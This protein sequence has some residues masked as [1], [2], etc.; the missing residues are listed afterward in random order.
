M[1]PDGDNAH[2]ANKQRLS[3]P[4]D[5]KILKMNMKASF[6]IYWLCGLQ[7]NIASLSLW[8][9]IDWREKIILLWEHN[10]HSRE[11]KKRRN[12]WKETQCPVVLHH[13]SM[14]QKFRIY[15]KCRIWRVEDQDI[16][17]WWVCEVNTLATGQGWK[18]WV[19]DFS[20]TEGHPVAGVYTPP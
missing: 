16:L 14:T 1:N 17:F 19:G 7:E 8:V 11:G 18:E 10:P 12:K 6:A 2:M 5:L 9:P 3:K 13:P 15:V 20:M 4:E